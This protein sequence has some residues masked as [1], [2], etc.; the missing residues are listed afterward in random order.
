MKRLF[1]I[2]F[3]LVA[4]V[5]TSFAADKAAAPAKGK[6]EKAAPAKAEKA[7]PAK[8]APAKAEKP[9][10]AKEEK[11]AEAK[12]P[13]KAAEKPK[14]KPMPGFVGKVV[15]T[16]TVFNSVSV[17]RGKEV[18][19]FDIANAK[20]KGYKNFDQVN[21]G[22]K[23]SML[24]KKGSLTMVKIAGAKKAKAE[25]KEGVKAKKPAKKEKKEAV[26]EQKPAE[27]K[28]PEAKKPAKK[29]KKEEKKEEKK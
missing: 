20:F 23:V 7:A 1:L 29:E 24:Y 4:F 5:S 18:V 12:E 16:D 6:A 3:V 17:Q 2:L 9:A 26:E 22:D 19:T 14:P 28:K 25:K 8:A 10:E 11:P 21:V 13:E 15:M 27:E